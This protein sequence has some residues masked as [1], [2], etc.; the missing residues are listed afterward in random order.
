MAWNYKMDALLRWQLNATGEIMRDP[1]NLLASIASV[2]TRRLWIC[3]GR[4]RPSPDR[5]WSGVFACLFARSFWVR[6]LVCLFAHLF[7]HLFACLILSSFIFLLLAHRSICAFLSFAHS[8]FI[9]LLI[10]SCSA[11]TWFVRVVL[12]QMDERT[13]AIMSISGQ[14]SLC[15]VEVSLQERPPDGPIQC[16]LDSTDNLAG[17]FIPFLIGL[18]SRLRHV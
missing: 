11:H 15:K 4:T 14:T 1:S 17:N 5:A 12:A 18:C 13:N 8:C 9:Q 6:S 3:K 7:I 16:E 2:S 10:W